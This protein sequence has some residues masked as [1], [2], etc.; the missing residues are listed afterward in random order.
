MA[1]PWID[2]PCPHCTAESLTFCVDA[3]FSKTRRVRVEPHAARVELAERT[4][5]PTRAEA[6]WNILC[7]YMTVVHE[8]GGPNEARLD[9]NALGVSDTEL[10]ELYRAFVEE[11]EAS[12]VAAKLPLVE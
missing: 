2:V 12:K 10:A 11:Q 6:I 4:N 8:Y 9:L 5:Y 7:N 1:I 3:R